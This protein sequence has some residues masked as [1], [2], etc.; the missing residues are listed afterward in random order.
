MVSVVQLQNLLLKPAI[1]LLLAHAQGKTFKS[2]D[3]KNVF[4]QSIDVR[5]EAAHL[6]L[7]ETAINATGRL[8][9]WVNNAGISAW[10]PI[11]TKLTRRFLIN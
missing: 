10:K 8:D 2:I 1:R 6:K 11:T 3:Q 4:F 9:A 7:A 5:E